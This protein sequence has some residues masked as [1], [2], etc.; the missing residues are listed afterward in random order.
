MYKI[1]NGTK[2][3]IS[4]KTLIGN[5]YVA[6]D[7][8]KGVEVKIDIMR[9]RDTQGSAMLSVVNPKEGFNQR[10]FLVVE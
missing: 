5:R 9:L 10:F 4:T 3:D 8:K 2:T 1:Y 6:L 7:L